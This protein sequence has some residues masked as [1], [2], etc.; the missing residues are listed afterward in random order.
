M[1]E[2]TTTTNKN[3]IKPEQKLGSE[4][5]LGQSNMGGVHNPALLPLTQPD[6]G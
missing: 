4:G 3:F 1:L 2:L 5:G 6:Y